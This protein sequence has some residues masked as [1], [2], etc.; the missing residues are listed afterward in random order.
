MICTFINYNINKNLNL[1]MTL[2]KSCIYF[3]NAGQEMLV[4]V[5]PEE[6]CRPEILPTYLL[7][8]ACYLR[9]PFTV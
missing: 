5:F 6:R 4:L 3:E 7:T 2:L 1:F 9:L 8:Y